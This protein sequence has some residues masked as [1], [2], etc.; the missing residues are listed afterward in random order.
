L[1][2]VEKMVDQLHQEDLQKVTVSVALMVVETH[3]ILELIMQQVEAVVQQISEE[4][5]MHYP[6]ELL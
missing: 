2:V 4:V 5:V 1:V 6:I 3:L